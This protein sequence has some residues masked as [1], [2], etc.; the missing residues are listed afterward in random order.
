MVERTARGGRSSRDSCSCIVDVCIRAGA[1]SIIASGYSVWI[2]IARVQSHPQESEYPQRALMF[3]MH[4]SC[5]LDRCMC[6]A[7]CGKYPRKLGTGP[8]MPHVD[9]STW[10]IHHSYHIS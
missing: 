2:G 4:A 8:S 7:S 6:S 1:G 5:K 3:T 10:K 9:R